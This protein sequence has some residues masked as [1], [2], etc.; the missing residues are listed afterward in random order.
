MGESKMS[1]QTTGNSRAYTDRDAFLDLRH[2]HDW[3]AKKM[4]V[5]FDQGKAKQAT[6]YLEERLGD[7]TKYLGVHLSHCNFGE[8]ANQ[9][10][11]GEDDCPALSESWSWLGKALQQLA[12]IK[13]SNE[14]RR[15][16]LRGKTAWHPFIVPDRP[17]FL[18][19]REAGDHYELLTY[20]NALGDP[21]YITN[22]NALPDLIR[23]F[24]EAA[25]RDLVDVVADAIKEA[26]RDYHPTQ[27]D[28]CEM[29]V[30]ALAAERK[31]IAADSLKVSSFSGKS[32]SYN[33]APV[34]SPADPAAQEKVAEVVEKSRDNLILTSVEQIGEQI[35]AF[36]REQGVEKAHARWP[37][38]SEE[39]L[40]RLAEA[41][42]GGLMACSPE[43]LAEF[44]E[45]AKTNEDIRQ[46]LR[47]AGVEVPDEQRGGDEQPGTLEVEGDDGQPDQGRAAGCVQ[48]G[49][50][51][52]SENGDGMD[53]ER[54]PGSSE[55]S[56]ACDPA[57]G[58]ATASRQAAVGDQT[59][60]KLESLRFRLQ[61]RR[62][63]LDLI[64]DILHWVP[65]RKMIP[66]WLQARWRIE[67]FLRVQVANLSK[68][69]AIEEK[70]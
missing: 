23:S 53:I 37:E 35:G 62:E 68:A 10:K 3:A 46:T 7:F 1:D 24:N 64:T 31:K 36:T 48:P 49:S 27:S 41:E 47:A 38:W 54:Q 30:A 2:V 33:V 57:A 61:Q 12:R 65:L 59:I 4:G 6:D 19:W 42:P 9:C 25:E 63:E 29:A 52:V 70:K 18:A 15:R 67:N 44:K 45:A 28:Y 17:D 69:I 26:H 8:N 40:R 14:Q 50:Q 5:S 11:Y 58:E 13:D 43:L 16:E 66:T 21:I 55:G 60:T 51:S 56:T 39:K 32:P 22:T 34:W 20:N